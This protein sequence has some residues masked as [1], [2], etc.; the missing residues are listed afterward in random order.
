MYKYNLLAVL[1]FLFFKQGFTQNDKIYLSVNETTKYSNVHKVYNVILNTRFSC[2]DIFVFSRDMKVERNN[3]CNFT[4]YPTT[5]KQN[6]HIIDIKEIE[7]S[8]TLKTDTVIIEANLPCV[9]ARFWINI[10]NVLYLNDFGLIELNENYANDYELVS[11]SFKMGNKT[12]VNFGS[13]LNRKIVRQLNKKDRALAITISNILVRR[14]D[15]NIAEINP[16]DIALKDSHTSEIRAV[17]IYM[18]VC[19]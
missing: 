16:I 10:N 14:P 6:T 13:K 8:I 5:T 15:K 18:D 19:K 9:V 4:L 17:K 1:L 12:I 7:D 11:F 2:K 3:D